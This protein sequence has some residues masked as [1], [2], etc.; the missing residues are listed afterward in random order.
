MKVI[1]KKYLK[2]HDEKKVESFS[3]K[4]FLKYH[5]VNQM[6]PKLSD[7]VSTTDVNW[8]ID[9]IENRK[10]TRTV[11]SGSLQYKSD[12]IYD[13][14]VQ[15]RPPCSVTSKQELRESLR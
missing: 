2:K 8:I 10:R 6:Y 13:K 15:K 9:K 11:V 7:H 14:T 1:F 3:V 5:F 4:S 12:P